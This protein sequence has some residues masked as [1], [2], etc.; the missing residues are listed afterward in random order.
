MLQRLE[1][2]GRA[3]RHIQFEALA[4]DAV[5]PSQH[6]LF[7]IHQ[8]DSGCHGNASLKPST[9][10]QVDALPYPRRIHPTA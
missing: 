7:V 1:R 6:V 8:Q 3:Q 9:L 10:G 2:L 5:V 4:Q